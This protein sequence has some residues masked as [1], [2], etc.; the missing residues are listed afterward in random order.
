[1][2]TIKLSG[3]DWSLHEDADGEGIA[4]H[5]FEAD[6]T[7]PG[8]IPATVPGN[9]QADVEAAHLMNPI[10][11]GA[12]DPRLAE[13]AQKD[14]WYRKD[15]AVPASFAG[16]R[17][18]LVFDGVDEDCEVWLNGHK[19]GGNKGM[20]RRFWFD[21]AS[22][23]QPGRVNRLAVKID[24][25]PPSLVPAMAQ[26]D[27]H[28]VVAAIDQVIHLLN[29]LKSPTN[30]AY[31]WAI[32]VYTLGIWKDVRLEATGPARIE[33]VRAQSELDKD[34]AKAK[35][36]VHL[37]IDSLAAMKVK[38][39]FRISGQGEDIVKTEDV[40]LSS[41]KNV[42]M[43]EIPVAHPALWWPNGQGSQPLYQLESRLDTESGET[44]DVRSVR[45][46]IRDIQ[47]I[48]DS[49]GLLVNGRQVRQMGSNLLP[50]DMLFG[51]ILQRG[52]RL[53]R[54]AAAA[55]MNTFR[56]WG[57]GVILPE[58][59]YDLADE[60]GIM[61]ISEFPLANFSPQTNSV[62]L[63]NLETTARNCV[64]QVRNHPC[65]IE[66]NAGNE[67]GWGNHPAIPLLRK[68]VEEE[69]GRVFRVDDCGSHYHPFG[70]TDGAKLYHFFN[71]AK[72]QRVSEFSISSPA[73]LETWYR[74]IPLTSQWPLN[75]LNDPVLFRKKAL[76]MFTPQT[77]LNKNIADRHFGALD[78]LPELI[79]A[80]QFLSAEEWRYAIDALRRRGTSLPG[81]FMTWVYNEPWPNAAGANMVDYD[82]RTL[83]N[84]DFIKQALAPVSLSLQYDSLFYSPT[85]GIKAELFLASDA[86]QT[87][88]GLHWRW[89]ARDRRGTVFARNEGTAFIAPLEVKS[90]GKM[91]LKPPAK[92]LFGP[93]FVELRI[94][95][96]KGTLLGERLYVF[97]LD[98]VASPFRGLLMNRVSDIDDEV[99][100]LTT[101]HTE[102][103]WRPVRRTTLN[104]TAKPLRVEGDE[105]VLE[106]QVKNTGRMTALFCEP[107]PLINYRTDLFIDNNHCFIPPGE[108]RTLTIRASKNAPGGLSL[109]ETG[110]WVSCWNANDVVIHPSDTVLLAVGR[111]D[112][113]CREYLGYF[114]PAKAKDAKQTVLQ[115]G[116]PDSSRLPYLMN[117]ERLARFEF[118]A[119][120]SKV[121]G[122][123]R[124]RI[125]TA[126]QSKDTRTV[127]KVT[128]NDRSIE[129]ALP[130]GIGLQMANPAQLAFPAT[131]VFEV[132]PGILRKGR[133]LM[134]VRVKNDGWFTWDAADLVEANSNRSGLAYC[135][136]Q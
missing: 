26:A 35:V 99:S 65:I 92:T 119:S 106:L 20:F 107:H 62:F 134:E 132:Q 47:W 36:R 34:H 67:I 60:L 88:T 109:S 94:D 33:W 120:D 53:V 6:A 40:N 32:A 19:I 130:E 108:S 25:I 126:D 135:R 17:V 52:P 80:G 127:V 85:T 129:Q 51:R 76:G 115:G 37:D 13:V 128:I 72:L 71:T 69:D 73:N 70:Q 23:L 50:P 21:V 66:W 124:L 58:E 114:D 86:P 1:M 11:Y 111:R 3:V 81:G 7:S 29:E 24:R 27:R 98:G 2:P 105:E 57:G 97:G 41:G 79:R 49:L 39:S 131:L 87:A 116:R 100:K 68:V 123:A 8:W 89:L 77:W 42:V 101:N 110:W 48:G 15:F 10:N 38:A 31:D 28:D 54:L 56:V 18:T 14:W 95:D 96:S 113:M 112:Q 84:Y 103:V 61:L 125:Y 44:L 136:G 82:G 55:G 104:V 90:L 78:S 118:R 4:Q 83:M 93:A 63:A 91:E 9:I 45:F 64:R 122:P 133:N 102:T 74:D 16:K 59:M 12:G 5:L 46:G 117:G 75:N 121:K 30:A 22:V 43:V